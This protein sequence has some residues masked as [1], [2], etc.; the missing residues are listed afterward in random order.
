MHG[1]VRRWSMHG[2]QGSPSGVVPGGLIPSRKELVM[3][4]RRVEHRFQ[5]GDEVV[6]DGM[7]YVV[8]E[9]APEMRYR[10]CSG[11]G[12]S[13]F[14]SEDELKPAPKPLPDDHIKRFWIPGAILSLDGGRQIWMVGPQA[15]CAVRPFTD[16]PQR[17]TLEELPERNWRF[18]HKSPIQ[19]PLEPGQ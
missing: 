5:E 19:T 8:A 4:E 3:H 10:V 1:L 6:C 14:V 16:P 18:H 15:N 12:H 17:K 11:S 13:Y 7:R 9:F 2:Q